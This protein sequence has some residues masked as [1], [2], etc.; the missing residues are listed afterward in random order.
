L[1]GLS[2]RRFEQETHDRYVGAARLA[3]ILVAA[4]LLRLM[5]MPIDGYR[6]DIA[7]FAGWAQL[8][9]EYG[10]RGLYTHVEPFSRHVIDYPPGYPIVL[11]GIAHL[12]AA[13]FAGHDPSHTILRVLLKLPASLA[14]LGLCVLAFRIVRRWRSTR[15]ALIA[16]A[17]AAFSP[18]TWMI[19]AYWGQV[20]SVAALL[21]LV[22]IACV[23]ERRFTIG[24]VALAL[25]VLVK[26][27]PIVIAPLLL[28]W[29][30]RER[31]R[32]W[33]LV[34]GPAAALVVAYLVALPFAPN[35]S[36][37]ATMTWLF[38]RYEGGVALYPYASVS[39]CNLFTI[40]GQY[41]ARDVN[42]VLGIPL[43]GWGAAAFGVLAVTIVRGAWARFGAASTRAARE[44][45]LV[46]G[47]F[48][49]LVGL[50]VL[51]TR[52]HERYLFSAIALVPILWFAARSER[53]PGIVLSV[54]FV[55]NCLLELTGWSAVSGHG[56]GLLIRLLSTVNLA[57]LV[58][59]T[60]RFAHETFAVPAPAVRGA[61]VSASPLGLRGG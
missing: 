29:Q 42:R 4:L 16:A 24:W 34:G 56:F 37:F 49:V 26:P 12:Y 19:S 21:M 23:F 50:F 48:I 9:V 14:D 38:A 32:S 36:P 10:T 1:D 28:A 39:A 7:T 47:C 15:E 20:D 31:G 54:T 18:A 11:A 8:I 35:A 51:T 40:V 33:S 61:A 53:V 58:V 30:L 45:L 6:G 5:L 41:Y 55:L 3:A 52:M 27:Q 13:C 46:R 17:I 57:T 60:Y 59:L 43:W 25:A 44:A 22:A 2:V